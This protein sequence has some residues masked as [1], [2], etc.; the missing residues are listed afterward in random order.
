MGIGANFM[1]TVGNGYIFLLS[2]SSL[3]SADMPTLS[4]K[5]RKNSYDRKKTEGI[6]NEKQEKIFRVILT[7]FVTSKTFM[8][9]HSP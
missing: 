5:M 3:A 8:Y 4:C 1:G 7:L 2:C 9:L 6:L